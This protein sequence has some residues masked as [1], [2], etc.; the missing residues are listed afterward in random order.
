MFLIRTP[1]A[2]AALLIVSAVSAQT[3]PPT[4]PPK[5]PP[6]TTPTIGGKRTDP[7]FPTTGGTPGKSNV[8]FPTDLFRMNEVSKSIELTDRQVNQLNLMTEKLQTRYRQQFDRLGGL[9]AQDQADRTLL[10]NRE[11]INAWLSGSAGILNDRQLTR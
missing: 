4:P 7:I 5:T 2:V 9:S 3:Q 1:A 8:T 6:A 11:Y 10:L